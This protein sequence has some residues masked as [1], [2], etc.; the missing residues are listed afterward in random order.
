MKS[1]WG[2]RSL[3]FKIHLVGG[4]IAAALL[5]ILGVTGSIMAFES[6]IDSRLHPS[7][8]HVVPLGQ[9]LPLTTLAAR[10]AAVTRPDERVGIYV[11]PTKPDNSCVVTLLAPGRLPRQV[12]VD[13][14]SGRVLGSLSVVRFVVVAHGLHEASGAVM[15]WTAIILLSS[16]TSGLYLWWPLKRIKIGFEGPARRVCFDLHNSAGFFSSLFLLVFGAT[17]AYMAFESVSVPA[18]YKLTGSQQLPGDP[19]STHVPGA[20]PISADSA[21]RI[22]RDFLPAA[23]PLWIV[24]PEEKTS[25]YL[26]KMR[27][28]EDHS[29]NGASIVWVDQFSG[30]VLAAWNSR[31]APVARKIERANRDLHSGDIWGYPSRVLACL[32]SMLLVVQAITGPYLWWKR[33]CAERTGRVETMP[34]G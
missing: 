23:V 5:L 14:Y 2:W 32:M 20:T 3:A 11:L 34:T 19:P 12:F 6:E 25:S 28:P 33:R 13:E 27:F 8:F 9:A 24:M 30:K 31:T 21:L 1:P 17:G 7:L 4:L 15:G 26:V 10:V 16:V 22:A 29:S 18:T